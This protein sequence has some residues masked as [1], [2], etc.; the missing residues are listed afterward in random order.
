M[1]LGWDQAE[2]AHCNCVQLI[3][4]KVIDWG[5]DFGDC[6]RRADDLYE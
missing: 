4:L 2:E 5:V 6:N 3:C 1:I